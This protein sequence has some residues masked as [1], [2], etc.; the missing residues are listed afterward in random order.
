MPIYEYVCDSCE[1]QFELLQR[2]GAP[3]PEACPECGA[4]QVRKLI[5][6]TNFVLRGSGWYRD[7]YGLKSSSPSASSASSKQ[8]SSPAVAPKAESTTS[9][10]SSGGK[11]AM[12]A[13]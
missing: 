9:A 3:P 8:S 13:K 5:S 1:H 2:V 11:T 6:M 12:A 7:H 10:S 4:R